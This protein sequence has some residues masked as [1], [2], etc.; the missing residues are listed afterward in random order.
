LQNSVC[1]RK[2]DVDALREAAVELMAAQGHQQELM[3]ILEPRLIQLTC[4]WGEILHRIRVSDGV[5]FS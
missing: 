5:S 3:T 4:R 2:G 1:A